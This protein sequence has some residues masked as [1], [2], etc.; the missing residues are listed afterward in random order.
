M[1]VTRA[2]TPDDVDNLVALEGR[3]FEND[4]ISRRSFRNLIARPTAE[5]IVAEIDGELAGYAMIL[6]RS[7]TALAR[8]YSI[9]VDPSFKGKGVSKSLLAAAESSAFA[10]DRMLLRLE[11]RSDNEV[12]KSL[13]SKSGY[14]PIGQLDAYYED[15]C[16]ALRF[17]KV[18]KGSFRRQASPPFY[19]QS[20]D[21][22]CGSACLLMARAAFIPDSPM[23]PVEEIRL[24]REATTVFMLSGPGGCEPFGLAVT[25]AEH[26]LETRIVCSRQGPLFLDTVRSDEKRRVME[27]AQTDFRQR[28]AK[29]GIAH[30]IREITLDELRSELREGSLAIVLLS[31]YRMFNKKVPHWVLAHADDGSHIV[32][33]DPWVE[34][35][36][37]ESITDASNLPIPYV[38][39][40]RMARFGKDRLQA[41]VFIK[42][43]R[44]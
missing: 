27:I 44:K 41:A 16:S 43:A 7:G 6:F 33:H 29:L 15:G 37:D 9:A 12:A 19:E 24:W 40:E 28:A 3:S 20:E 42:G 14:H 21:F 5:T 32:V 1:L 18:L 39:F 26:G 34:E 2:A 38:W 10:H 11:V 30:D 31:G 13:Y 35:H 25:A 4:R 23:N 22:T 36:T 17:E 8:L